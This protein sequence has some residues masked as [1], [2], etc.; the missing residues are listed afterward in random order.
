MTDHAFCLNHH[1]RSDLVKSSAYYGLIH[2]QLGGL[3]APAAHAERK[4]ALQPL[5]QGQ[6]LAA[7]SASKMDDLLQTLRDQCRDASVQSGGEINMTH[8]IFAFTND[9]MLSYVLGGEAPG[10]G[11]MQGGRG[12]L[13]AAHDETRA[14]GAIDLATTMRAMPV[15]KVLLDVFPSLRRW[16]PMG[17]MDAVS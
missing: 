6:T 7:F 16:S 2:R 1:R 8:Q 4:Q 17:W 15:F 11:F 12:N 5:F 14:F 3:A 13:R 10:T 9:V